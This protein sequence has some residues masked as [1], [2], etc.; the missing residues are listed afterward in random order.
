MHAIV[1]LVGAGPGDPD[2]LTIKAAR[3]IAIAGQLIAKC[4]IEHGMPADIPVLAI[5]NGTLT[6]ERRLSSTLQNIAAAV[7]ADGFANPVSFIIGDVAGPNLALA[8]VRVV[9]HCVA[10]IR[11]ATRATA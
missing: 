2:L 3:T 8:P 4:L 6:N 7:M 9:P 5:A 1:F 10:P 11:E